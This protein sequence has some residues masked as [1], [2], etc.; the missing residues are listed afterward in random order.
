[1]RRRVRRL[2]WLERQSV[3]VNLQLVE[4]MLAAVRTG[5]PAK[6]RQEEIES[7][8][9]FACSSRLGANSQKAAC[10]STRNQS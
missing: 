8:E 4:P 10:P 3:W 5:S 7:L 9:I 6:L 1:M 2:V